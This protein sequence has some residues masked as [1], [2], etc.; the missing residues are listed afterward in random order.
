VNEST[1]RVD[2]EDVMD[3]GVDGMPVREGVLECRGCLSGEEVL[4]CLPG[5]AVPKV[6]DSHRSPDADPR[7]S[8]STDCRM[9]DVGGNTSSTGVFL[10]R[11]GL[12][13]EL[14]GLAGLPKPPP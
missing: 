5:M 11:T 2:G 10:A 1:T 6:G 13:G 14:D 12:A 7:R 8:S 4:R 9:G 3:D